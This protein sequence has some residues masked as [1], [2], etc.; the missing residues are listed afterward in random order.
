MITPRSEVQEN[1]SD[2]NTIDSRLPDEGNEDGRKGH[3]YPYGQKDHP[4]EHVD[5]QILRE[6][7]LYVTVEPCIMCASLLRQ[8]GIRKVYFGA[9][10]DKFGGTGGVFS[11]HANSLP[12]CLASTANGT[13]FPNADLALDPRLPI[14]KPLR[15]R[16][17]SRGH[18]RH[19]A[20]A[21]NT[22][23]EP[24]AQPQA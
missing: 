19:A 18:R 4:D 22:P 20:A 16:V 10:N 7:T 11:I 2:T 5:R 12:M 8:L 1:D 9:V 3:L 15:P 14:I 23:I 13:A 6:S 17:E 21:R 24:E